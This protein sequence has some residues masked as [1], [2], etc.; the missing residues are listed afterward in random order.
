MRFRRRARLDPGQVTDVRG[1]RLG[2]GGLAAGGGGIGLA[3][4]IVYLV[5]TLL[6]PSGG[7][8]QLAPL[9]DRS[10]GQGDT[11][12]EVSEACQTGEDANEREDCRIVAVVNSVQKFW[13]GVFA[14]SNKR[15]PYV[16]TV[17]FT[18]QVQTGCGVASS[19]VGPF[20]CPEDQ[21]VYIDLD[22][23]DELQSRF[24]V[25][26]AP[27]AQAY[28]IAHEYGHH[29]QNQLGVLDS[30]RGDRQG[31]ESRAHGSSEQR[32]RWFSRGYEQGRPA[33]CDTFSGSI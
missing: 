22:F 28:V 13:D 27:F 30:I 14:R 7:L 16:D 3:V 24:G 29:V 31:P 20:Y 26:A 17:F 12:G 1:R 4:L 9:D 33:A 19:Q 8:G 2:G 15:Y 32:R 5:I 23:F 21:L 25:G 18:D 11:P 10:V 6:S